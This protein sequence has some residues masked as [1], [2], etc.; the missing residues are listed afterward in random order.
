M[1]ILSGGDAAAGVLLAAGV[2]KSINYVMAFG[3]AAAAGA[4]NIPTPAAITSYVTTVS[5][6]Y[7]AAASGAPKLDLIMKEFWIASFGNGVE[8]YN[9]YRRTGKPAQMQI[10]LS[11]NPG[12]YYRSFTY[13][14]IYVTR[15]SNATQKTSDAVQV[16]WDN[17]PAGFVN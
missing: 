8:A 17:N 9:N 11:A 6:R 13:P 2:T 15:N 7:A 5:T 14:S 12:Q 16:F 10:P 4:T 3:S 1:G